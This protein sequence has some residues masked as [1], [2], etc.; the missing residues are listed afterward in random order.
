MTDVWS[1]VFFINVYIFLYHHIQFLFEFF[2]FSTISYWARTVSKCFITFR[3]CYAQSPR[4]LL[5]QLL[6]EFFQFSTIIYWARTI[7]KWFITF[8]SRYAKS[9]RILLNIFKYS[10]FWN[11]GDTQYIIP[12]L[13]FLLSLPFYAYM[14]TF[15]YSCCS[16]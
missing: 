2:Q 4:I 5:L 7:S 15:S 12:H 13:I 6:F 14:L 9:P 1:K 11:L 8:R 10:D 3:S 16:W